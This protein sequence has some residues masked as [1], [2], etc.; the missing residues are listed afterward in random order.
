MAFIGTNGLKLAGALVT[1]SWKL[2]L[3]IMDGSATTKQ[4]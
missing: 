1:A 3:N 4:Q 2:E